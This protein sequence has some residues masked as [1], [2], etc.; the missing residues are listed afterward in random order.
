MTLVAKSGMA[1]AYPNYVMHIVEALSRI[2]P[3]NFLTMW[4][5]QATRYPSVQRSDFWDYKAYSADKPLIKQLPKVIKQANIL[6]ENVLESAKLAKRINV[7]MGPSMIK[8]RQFEAS[9]LSTS[10]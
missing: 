9:Q 4:H 7:L 5:E 1:N 10:Q 8:L 2:Y 6:S 3:L